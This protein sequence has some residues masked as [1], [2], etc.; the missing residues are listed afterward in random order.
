MQINIEK[1]LPAVIAL[2]IVVI[3]HAL[4]AVAIFYDHEEN[5]KYH[6]Y[7]GPQGLFLCA[8]RFVMFVA[9]IW[10]LWTRRQAE[11]Q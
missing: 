9:F 2:G 5:H 4:T 6:D 8:L 11:G 1:S 10:A 7:Q 3:C